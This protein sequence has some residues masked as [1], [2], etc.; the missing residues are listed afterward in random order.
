[1]CYLVQVSC[2][3][4]ALN[5]PDNNFILSSESDESVDVDN[6]QD[7]LATHE[8][9]H[10]PD[11]DLTTP[12]LLTKYGYPAETHE[13]I[14]QDGYV[15]T[16]HRIPHG[17]ANPI[18]Q[19][20]RPPILLHHGLLCSSVDWIMNTVDKALGYRL[21][22]LGYDVWLANSRGTT[23]SRNHV[24]LTPDQHQFWDF[25][26]H[27][28]GYYDLPAYFDYILAT[29]G[30]EKLH[31][32]GHSQGTVVFWIAMSEHPEYNDKVHAM[33]GMGPVAFLNG[34]VSPIR[35]LA[36]VSTQL[37][38]REAEA[39]F[40]DREFLP[41][42]GVLKHLNRLV[43][44]NK[45]LESLIC[46]NIM[47]LLC[48]FDKPQMNETTLP[49]VLAHTPAGTSS[50]TV[51]HF[52]QLMKSGKFRQF[53]Y[54]KRKNVQKYGSEQPPEYDLAKVTAKVA[55]YY[56]ENDWLAVPKDVLELSRALP[57]VMVTFKVK[58]EAF[59]HLDFLY[60]IDINKLLYDDLIKLL[61]TS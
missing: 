16:L 8:E 51:I 9:T 54:G 38:V 53:D 61:I 37:Q 33:F 13:V 26:F 29:T 50:H 27:E 10:N 28:V 40:G 55:L 47:F 49:V 5:H 58:L 31:Y 24:S 18:A 48:G 43:C 3:L 32:V 19:K 59:N 57:N 30:E 22:D 44:E 21:A 56:G 7:V 36:D 17:R 45:Y 52:A 42:N 23:Y 4:L 35:Y 2:R 25:S 46:E 14:T 1:M 34:T 39:L 15:L 20:R 6:F 41:N 12:E 60:A 11:E